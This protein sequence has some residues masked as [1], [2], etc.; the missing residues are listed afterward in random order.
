MSDC[1][2]VT[3]QDY[4][5]SNGA[6]QQQPPQLIT[7]QIQRPIKEDTKEPEP[8]QP[9]EPAGGADKSDPSDYA[10]PR[11]EKKLLIKTV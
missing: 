2:P 4:D 3:V 11:V 9:V 8:S 5:D 7:P 6:A 1:P 10:P